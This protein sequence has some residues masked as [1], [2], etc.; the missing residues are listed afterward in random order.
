MDLILSYLLST[1]FGQPSRT[2]Y[3][4]PQMKLHSQMARLFQVLLF[5]RAENM[6][7]CLGLKL[8]QLSSKTV[9]SLTSLSLGTRLNLITAA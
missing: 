1:L 6:Q 8:G 5:P 9:G 3:L 2:D 4:F 7:S